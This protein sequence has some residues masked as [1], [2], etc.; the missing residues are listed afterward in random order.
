[1]CGI[2]GIVEQKNV[3]A[4]L[5]DILE[6]LSYRGY[7][8][9]GVA[10][11]DSHAKI[12]VCRAA[13]KITNLKEKIDIHPIAGSVGI[14]HTRWAT[15]GAPTIRNAHPHSTDHVSV[16]HN[17]IIE[18]HEILRH[19]LEKSGCVFQ[20]D[21]DTEVI[22]HL[23]TQHLIN[24]SSPQD[25]AFKVFDALQG[26]FATA[27]IFNGYPDLIIG[28]CNATP[29][30][31]G[32][33]D[34]GIYLCSDAAIL[35]AHVD[36]I[37]SLGDG[38]RFIIHEDTVRFFDINGIEKTLVFLPVQN[39]ECPG[40][41]GNYHHF[42]QKEMFEQP[43][44]LKNILSTYLVDDIIK[45]PNLCDLSHIQIVACG[46]SYYAA[47]LAKYWFEAYAEIPVSVDIA[48]EYRY[49]KPY[50]YPNGVA[51]F[52]S[53][54]G[55]TADTVSA[56]KYAQEND[57]K[58]MA[59]VNVMDS[60]LA[61]AADMVIGTKAGPEIGVASTK[62][63][64]AQLL[65]LMLLCLKTAKDRQKISD[66]VYTQKLLDI[67]KLPSSVTTVLETQEDIEYGAKCIS[68]ASNMLFIGRNVY[69]P[70]AL[71]GALKLKELSYIHAEAYAAG[72]MKHGPIALIDEDMPVIA[73]S[74][75]G[76]LF[77]KTLSN[78]QEVAARGAKVITFTDQQGQSH[79]KN[80]SMVQIIL[81]YAGTMVTP[82]LYTVA[83]Q[84]LAYHVADL[85]GADIDQPRNLAKSVTVE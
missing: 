15:H 7:D 37:V 76:G 69:Y 79:S 58:T 73:L 59:I 27:M 36:E 48:S 25:A 70:I 11:L 85:K 63:F 52:I 82:I 64:T 31:L 10:L 6:R 34:S 55:E 19:K 47:L 65:V 21:T 39:K 29:M 14:G 60:F 30:V 54:S 46:T 17:G 33:T 75:S 3:I 84:L 22:P 49:R 71:E 80:L 16:V 56:M 41:K 8:S 78:I 38:D 26:A 23:V 28:G 2:V 18:N 81:P 57:Q 12:D 4:S 68:N 67:K 9:S 13:G 66:D 50:I 53:Q 42:M 62:A 83:M 43:L 5:V 40:D 1:M 72:E 20:S 74:P 35:S 61:R 77:D 45:M 24:G 51:I 44:V 32:R